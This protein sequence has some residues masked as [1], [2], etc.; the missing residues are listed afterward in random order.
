VC[1]G[2]TDAA[3]Q[4]VQ[5]GAARRVVRDRR[6]AARTGRSGAGRLEAWVSGSGAVTGSQAVD[7][8]PGAVTDAVSALG[9]G[10]SRFDPAVV[11]EAAV[12]AVV[13]DDADG[14]L[15][16]RISWCRTVIG[17]QA[18]DT[19][20]FPVANTTTQAWGP[21]RQLGVL[22][23][24]RVARFRVADGQD[25]AVVVRGAADTGAVP[26]AGAA[27]AEAAGGLGREDAANIRIAGGEVICAGIAII[28]VPGGLDAGA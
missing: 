11:V 7:A 4:A 8:N 14:D 24:S 20:T 3:G 19:G 18:F 22:A 9:P 5:P 26:V 6:L 2:C 25:R 23:I 13:L 28:A 1:W 21:G 17:G 27:G 10:W 15:A 12:P 16:G